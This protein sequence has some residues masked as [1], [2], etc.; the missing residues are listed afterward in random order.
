METI[1]LPR[2]ARDKHRK[3]WVRQNGVFGRIAEH[4]NADLA[5][6][7]WSGKGMFRNCCDPGEKMP[8]YWLQTLGGGNHTADWDHSRFVPGKRTHIFCAVLY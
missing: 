4:F 7:A 3:S 8:A 2:Q 5:L 1:I 6:V